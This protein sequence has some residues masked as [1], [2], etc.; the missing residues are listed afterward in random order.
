MSRINGFIGR[1]SF[2]KLS[3]LVGGSLMWNMQPTLAS[4]AN[5][6]PVNPDEALKRL[7]DGNNRFLRQK[8]LYPDQSIRRIHSVSQ[9]QHP[10]VSVLGCADS[11][12]PVE[13]IFDEGIGDIFDVRVAGNVASDTAI[14]S[15]EYATAILG[16]QLIVVLGHKRCGAVAEALLDET[17][18]GKISMLVD[19]IKPAVKDIKSKIQND[20]DDAVIANIHYQIAKLHENSILLPELQDKGKLKIVGAR[21]D[22]DSGKVFIVT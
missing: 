2:L 4:E 22:I 1:R 20:S 11:R 21:Y 3:G 19:K 13:I 5:L 9:A 7:I 8:R 12:V 16:S 14:G 15:L 6:N 18:P 17:A 10:F